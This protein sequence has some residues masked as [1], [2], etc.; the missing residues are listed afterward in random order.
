MEGK[1]APRPPSSPVPGLT[2][3]LSPPR[4]LNLAPPPPTA[5]PPQPKG[6]PPTLPQRPR[7]ASADTAPSSSAPSLD[8]PLQG[9]SPAAPGAA[10][11][12]EAASG[13]LLQARVRA[14]EEREAALLGA[15]AQARAEGQASARVI[16]ELGAQ[17]A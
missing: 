2:R 16:A 7:L 9:L 6:A 10:A 11:A 13:P 3:L 14:L 12:L 15:Q 4:G 8:T 1:P 17:L 5:P